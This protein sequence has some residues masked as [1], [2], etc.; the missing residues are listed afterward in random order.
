MWVGR[1]KKRIYIN[2]STDM[3]KMVNVK[4]NSADKMLIVLEDPKVHTWNIVSSL[5]TGHCATKQR[6]MR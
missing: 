4:E 5:K 1:N 2:R 3:N 6:G